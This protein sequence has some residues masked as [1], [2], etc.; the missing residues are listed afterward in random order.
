MTDYTVKTSRQL[1]AVLRG[2][3]KEQ[4]LTQ[5]EIGKKAAL[6]QPSISE[7][8]TDP[9]RAALSRVLKVLGALDLELVI[10]ERKNDSERLDW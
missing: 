4:S 5:Q 3:R 9:G 8:E 2:Y 10:R 1:G 6:P 7:M